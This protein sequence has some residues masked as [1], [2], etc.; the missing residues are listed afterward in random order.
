MDA[1]RIWKLYRSA[2]AEDRRV[3]WVTAGAAASAAV[4]TWRA[5]WMLGFAVVFTLLA[6]AVLR[7]GL[8]DEVLPRDPDDD[9]F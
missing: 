6:W 9:D 8:F 7:T 2:L 1:A 4:V 5:P 3:R